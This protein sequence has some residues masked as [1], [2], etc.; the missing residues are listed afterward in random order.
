MDW[1]GEVGE[2]SNAFLLKNE[3]GPLQRSLED[4]E[5]GSKAGSIL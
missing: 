2:G 1:V 5:K 3:L 4:R